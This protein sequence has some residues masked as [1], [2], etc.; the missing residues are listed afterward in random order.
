MATLCRVT[1]NAL[2][3]VAFV[4]GCSAD[5]AKGGA[6][7]S[8]GGA[9]KAAAP[10][11][12][13]GAKERAKDENEGGKPSGDENAEDAAKS[14]LA[15]A[16]AEKVEQ[17]RQDGGAGDEPPGPEGIEDP[18]A[19]VAPTE[20][21]AEHGNRDPTPLGGSLAFDLP[22]VAGAPG[23][24]ATVDGEAVDHAVFDEIY[25]LKVKKYRDRGRDIPA[26][27]ARRY[28][29]SISERMI[30]A[31]LLRQRAAKDGV[32]YDKAE[33]ERRREQQKRGIRDWEKHLERR[34]E[35]E[36]SLDQLYIAELREKAILDKAGRLA[37]SRAD[38]EADYD[39]IK[40]NWKSKKPRV[41]AS[42]I[43]IP[44][45]GKF[46]DEAAAKKE[47]QRLRK[48]AAKPG[49]DFE[50]L[51]RAHSTGPSS[52]KGGDIGIFTHDR[53]AEEFSDVAFKLKV[54]Q[55][56]KVVKTKFG[57]HIIK[58]TGKWPPGELPMSALEDQITDRLSQRKLHQG[59][60]LLKDELIKD[61]KID[62]HL[63]PIKVEPALAHP[64]T[65]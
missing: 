37:V 53:M 28:I 17:A 20:E 33:L 61:A 60:R 4:L 52:A 57:F 36:D 24:L 58:L 56:S 50:A 26:S 22:V 64:P 11:D 18:D 27:A 48:L 19:I 9:A 44:I 39:K 63:D 35:T 13:R 40:G 8:E 14:G 47:A 42:H 55:V 34:G 21:E 59:R 10:A 7:K 16:V 51:A 32:D 5:A 31:E 29:K 23:A 65:E 15:G 3:L 45:D 41:K 1:R 30:Y 46:A 62:V 49:A 54:G 2:I 43:L 38:I 25:G 6:S 12:E